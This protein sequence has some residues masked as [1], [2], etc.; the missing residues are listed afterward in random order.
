MR[1]EDALEPF[2]DFNFDSV[3]VEDLAYLQ[4]CKAV[5]VKEGM[6]LEERKRNSIVY[7]DYL[8]AKVEWE[9]SELASMIEGN[10]RDIVNANGVISEASRVFRNWQVETYFKTGNK[11]YAGG[12][13]RVGSDIVVINEELG[14]KLLIDK[15]LMSC[16]SLDMKAV[17]K[18][19]YPETIKALGMEEA[20]EYVEKPV[21]SVDNDLSKWLDDER[22]SHGE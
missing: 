5:L 22:F 17:K 20:F 21:G 8:K 12:G 16:L 19:L 1:Y 9:N 2:E 7:Q 11:H 4:K 14:K 18:V 3:T 15:G 13:V 10:E 6:V